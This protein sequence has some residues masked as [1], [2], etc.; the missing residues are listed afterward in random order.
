MMTTLDTITAIAEIILF[1]SLTVLVFYLISSFKKITASV[2]KIEKD[3]TSLE[4]KAVPLF[5]NLNNTVTEANDLARDLKL[6]LQ[7]IYRVIDTVKDKGDEVVEFTARIQEQI[8]K[9]VHESV[10][11]ISAVSNGIKAFLTRL[12]QKNNSASLN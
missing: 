12:K 10:N 8:G 9:P 2:Q 4:S 7:K 5:D 1:I 6:N 11:F 3:I